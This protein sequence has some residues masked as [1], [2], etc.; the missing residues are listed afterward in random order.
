MISSLQI[1]NHCQAWFCRFAA[2][3]SQAHIYL[4]NSVNKCTALTPIK[5]LR[6]RSD[7]PPHR[8]DSAKISLHPPCPHIL[9][10]AGVPKSP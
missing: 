8:I 10:I 4:V 2:R 7:Q 9:S 3:R 5:L 1:N 6:A